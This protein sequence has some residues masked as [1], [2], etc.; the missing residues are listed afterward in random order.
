LA[1][2]SDDVLTGHDTNADTLEG[3]SGDDTLTGNSGGADT[4]LGG[5]GDDFLSGGAGADRIDGGANIDTVTFAGSAG[6]SVDLAGSGSG[7]DAQGDTYFNIE[8]V[9]GSSNNDT[10]T[11]TVADN[12]IVGG[13]GS[14]TLSGLGGNDTLDGGNGDDSLVGG[15]GFDQLIGGAG[16]DTVDYSASAQYIAINLMAAGLNGDAIGDTYSSIENAIGTNFADTITGTLADNVL[17]GLAGADSL[18]GGDGN[19]TLIGGAGADSLVGGAG[20]DTADYALSATITLD[21]HA[22]SATGGDAAGDTF[23]SVERFLG[24]AGDDR[25]NL[26]NAAEFID[27]R[28]GVDRV[29]YLNSTSGVTVNLGS[30]S[31]SGGFAAG[32]TYANIEIVVG[33]SH[34][35]ELTGGAGSD[36]LIGGGGADVL[37]GAGGTDTVQYEGSSNYTLD[38]LGGASSGGDAAGDTY[39]NIERF[40]TFT[41]N[42]TFLMGNTATYVD[43]GAGADIVSYEN[44]TGAVTVNLATGG[45]GGW[46]TGDTYANIETV[47]GSTSGD[48]L[49][50]GAGNDTL[51]G[52][53]G[54]D[55]L[56]GAGGTGDTARYQG[57]SDLTINLRGGASSG[58][59]ANGDT[60]ANMERFVTDT[61]NDTFLMGSTA[62]HVDGGAGANTVSY[63]T[64]GSVTVNLTTG[65]TGGWAAGDTYANITTVL[66]SSSNDQLTG[67]AGDDTL[68]GNDGADAL[69]GSGGTDTTRYDGGVDYTID[70]R[71][72]A[73][74]GGD[75]AGDTYAN[76]ERF[77]TNSGNDTFLMGDTATY[78]EGGSGTDTVSY[79]T[80]GAVTFNLAGSGS[81]GWA[82]GDTYSGIENATGS[83]SND[84][85][86]GTS[87]ANVLR[88]L[89]GSDRL[90]GGDG[91]DTLIGGAGGDTLIGGDGSDTVDYN[92]SSA[93]TL[94]LFGNS[95]TGGDAAGDTFSSIERYLGTSGNDTFMMS[96]AGEFIDGRG[97]ADR[98]QYQ[99]SN[100][101]VVISLAAGTGSGGHAAGDTFAGIEI[102]VGSSFDDQLTGSDGDD[103]LIGDGGADALIGGAGTDTAQYTGLG[104]YT[105]NLWGGASSVGDAQGDTYTSIERFV[106]NTGSDTFLMGSTATHIDGGSGSDTASYIDATGIVVVDLANGGTGG[107]ANGDTYANIENLIGSS[108]NDTLTGT[109]NGDDIR[110]GDGN[111]TISGLGG[112]DTLWGGYGNDTL[113][114]GSGNDV[115]Q[116]EV[117]PGNGNDTLRGGDGNDTLYSYSGTD[118]LFGDADNDRLIVNGDVLGGTMVAN[119]GSGYDTLVIDNDNV[120]EANLIASV[121]NIEELNLL[122]F[123]VG[124]TLDLSAADIAALTGQAQ[125]SSNELRV[126]VNGND[127]ITQELQ[128]GES[129][130]TTNNF[131]GD[132]GA[133]LYSYLDGSNNEIARLIL[134]TTP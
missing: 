37:D 11:G 36:T 78:V 47:I 105:I 112:T 60:Y 48:Q 27:G 68:I 46:A 106:T 25:F 20:T 83:N 17:T 126:Y 52:G 127:T 62:T 32:D 8:H 22:N 116:D 131:G 67:G 123:W 1:A 96:A 41:G 19:D 76:M 121:T 97:G 63:E 30:G 40:V 118:R 64:A 49:T 81:V 55:V 117:M 91:N 88:G 87:G 15:D 35:D 69:D 129:V 59:D 124:L 16:T 122:D 114:G 90:D 103:T 89:N 3:M 65:G 75:A 13:D 51:I 24:T 2:D 53:D 86:T 71:G 98:I 95:A 110:G 14:D 77:I 132:S 33:S 38:L 113:E 34:D 57:S 45:T 79:E 42:D 50:G 66:G 43:G 6:V 85:I 128:A 133:T 94:N 84:S 56:D 73:S 111:D 82:N 28:A 9:I 31:G 119:G 5:A 99:D 58:G 102:V 61:G 93:I 115:L 108:F 70:L 29:Q 23:S 7:G 72:G 4:L 104:S 125:G 109:N 26:S 44:A 74:S 134:D 92:G 80:A 107:W 12:S 100:A 120:T 21:L 39:S 54:A 130:V 10:I 101:A 18:D